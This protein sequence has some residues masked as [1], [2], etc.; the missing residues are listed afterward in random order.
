MIGTLALAGI[1]PFAGF[2]SKDEI[3]AGTGS[4]NEGVGNYH[5]ALI[6]LLIGAF[7][8]A[9]Y[10]TR[11]I[12]YAFYN[13][14]YKGHGH[15]HESGPVITWPLIILAG[16][17]C[18]VWVLNLPAKFL[19]DWRLPQQFT[20]KFEHYVEPVGPFFPGTTANF[21]HAEFN[22]W[23]ATLSLIVAGSGL[24]LAYLFYFKR[25]LRPLEGL[26][27]RNSVMGFLKRV[28][29]NKYYLDWLYTDIIVGSIKKPIAAAAYWINQHVLDGVVNGAGKSAVVSGRWVY[30][31][32]DQGVIDGVVNGTGTVA[33]AS[34]GE[35]RRVQTGRVQQYAALFFAAAAILAGVFVLVIG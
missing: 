23:I 14:E 9:A 5:F 33:N 6:M 8:T 29:V 13:G 24:G 35:L 22:G 10:M 25:A 20:L 4:A 31:K 17:T 18:T 28:L 2:W 32:I 19:F 27:A 21:T 16:L 1:F 12:W 34:G 7:C 26:A 3:L 11:T 30:E 15:P